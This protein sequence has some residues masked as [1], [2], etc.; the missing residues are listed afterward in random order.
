MPQ[1]I[2]R[3]RLLPALLVL[4]LLQGCGWHLRGQSE[5]P[6]SISP[7]Y[8]QGAAQFDRL[9]M[10]LA[11]ALASN[12]LEVS[13]DPKG[14]AAV[15]R[16]RD[17][18]FNKRTLSVLGDTG[19]VAEYELHDQVF[20]DVTDASGEILVPEQR[21]GVLR[22]YLNLEDEVLGKR[23]EEEIQRKEMRQELVSHIIRRLQAHLR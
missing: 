20:F 22:N 1:S 9:R 12:N 15:L 6:S 8:I 13:S 19:K 4:A 2:R 21:V 16:I 11:K 5:L 3:I 18:E 7:I 17:R 23:R 14:A 10:D